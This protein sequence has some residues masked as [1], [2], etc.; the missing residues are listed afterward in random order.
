[1]MISNLRVNGLSEPLGYH[2]DH[3]SFS[4]DLLGESSEKLIKQQ[5]LIAAD[6]QL[7]QVIKKVETKSSQNIVSVSS[8]FLFPRTRYYW[9]VTTQ[10]ESG[11][12]EAISH[13]ETGKLGESWEANWISYKDEV[14]DSVVFTKD[15]SVDKKIKSARLYC[16]GYGL[17]EASLNGVKV[18]EEVLLPG[19]HSYDLLNQYQTFDVTDQLQA[20]NHLSFLTGNGWYKG[21]FVFEGGYENIYG[22]RQKIIAELIIEYTDGSS[23]KITTNHSWTATTSYIKENSIYDGEVIDYCSKIEPLSLI[24]LN[25]EKELLAERSNPP[26]LKQKVLK[27]KKVFFDKEGKIILDFGQ[28]ITGW[29]EGSV[30]SEQIIRF[31]FSEL[32]QDNR[33]Y[34]ENLRTAKQEFMIYP[35]KEEKYIRPH[36]TFFGF[37]YVEAVGISRDQAAE[38]QAVA[39]YSE[40]EEL[41]QFESSNEK[42]NQLVRN[43][44]WSQRD[45]F[46]DIPTDCPQ[47]DERMGWTGDV[48]IF[49][50][51]S[52]YNM[53]TRS[54]YANYLRNLELEQA[55]LDGSVPFFVPYPK[56]PPHENIN[57]FLVSAGAAVW[58][59]VATILP[60]QLFRHYKD[61]GLFKKNIQ[62]MERWVTYL[63]ERDTAHGSRRL[64]DF[65]RQLGDWLALDTENPSSPMGATDPNLV[66]SIYYY[67]ST[68][69]LAKG[70]LILKDERA[71]F[72]QKLAKEIQ[73]A[74]IA[75]YY[76][77][78]KLQLEPLTQTGLALLLRNDLYPSIDAKLELQNKLVNI[79]KANNNFL[80]TGFV[81]TP[82]LTHA[83]AENGHADLAYTLLLNEACPSWL[84]EVNQGATT[85]WERWDSILPDGTISGTEMNSLNHYAYGAVEDF[86]IEKV[87]GLSHTDESSDILTIKLEPYFDRRLDWVKGS[88]KTANGPINISWRWRDEQVIDLKVQIPHD[89]RLLY[90]T[91]NH[92]TSILHSGEM[93]LEVIQ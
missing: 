49:A 84:Y 40:M 89:T 38:L 24:E 4:W 56:I 74:I 27:P 28:I 51:A 71:G 60:F 16:C 23:S 68:S 15:F 14:I 18:T 53:N 7:E 12:I 65:D 52:C 76:E 85:V 47:R 50:N 8:D 75:E 72:Y 37:R 57:P 45:N 5:L 1:M 34:R 11:T 83:L 36:F 32:L 20:H 3:L 63:Y 61:K 87:I 62:I 9:K 35:T 41:F 22:D 33:F 25:D 19:Y 55:E 77:N 39:V 21:R 79:L 70:L 81:G 93:V 30:A 73:Q 17:Y 90:T 43:I 26:I 86:I 6:P 91:S 58:G 67:K 82:E 13:F 54:F 69:Y 64:W 2:F 80:N 48:A 92:E 10:L 59:D 88:L 31:H 66:A 78:E 42:L 44:Q 46:L 29:L